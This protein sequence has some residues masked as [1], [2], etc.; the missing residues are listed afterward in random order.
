MGAMDST[1]LICHRCGAL[2]HR[3]DG[4]FH[5]VRIEAFADPSPPE[6]EMESSGAATVESLLAEASSYSA[7]EFMDQVYRRLELRLCRRCYAAWIED[8]TGSGVPGSGG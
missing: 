6:E 5:V 1:E 3:G 7:Q 8:P 2:L 4:S